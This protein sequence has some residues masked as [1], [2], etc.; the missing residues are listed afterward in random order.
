MQECSL[1]L[2]EIYI[3]NSGVNKKNEFERI[4]LVINFHPEL[5]GIG[6]NVDSLWPILQA[7]DDM[8]QIF[9]EKPLVSCTRLRNLKHKLVRP[10]FKDR[11]DLVRGNKK[12]W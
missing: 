2:Y 1:Y 11:I 5:S 8:K 4:P 12:M 10:K 6:K 9:K 3:L 7:S